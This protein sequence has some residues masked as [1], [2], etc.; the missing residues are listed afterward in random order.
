MTALDGADHEI[1]H[2][3]V[4]VSSAK[5][6]LILLGIFWAVLSSGLLVGIFA[7]WPR[8]ARPASVSVYPL[9]ATLIN[10]ES[11]Q[12]LSSATGSGDTTV[13]WSATDGDITPSGVFSAP[14]A[15]KTGPVTVTATRNSDHTQ[16]ASAQVTIRA[17][18]L[19]MN[20]S[21]VDASGMK[22]GEKILFQAMG[23]SGPATGLQWYLSGPGV[24]ATDG[25][26][27]V[28]EKSAAQAVVTAIDPAAG[29]KAAAVILLLPADVAR[30]GPLLLLVAVVGAFGALLAAV[31]S[32]V[33][34]VGSRTFVPSWS[35][36]YLFRPLFGAGLA[37][38]VFFAYRIGAVS[39]PTRGTPA[40]P[41]TAAFVAG[42]VGLFADTVLQKLKELVEQL[43][44]PQDTRSDKL[45][46]A[47]QTSVP[48]I[49]SLNVDGGVLTIQGNG[50]AAGAIVSLNG[51]N[52]PTTF[53]DPTKLTVTL[54]DGLTGQVSVIVTNHDGSRSA[55][56]S[57][58][59][60]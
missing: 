44:R 7:L 32:F 15:P 49:T 33:N 48:S 8:P 45:A 47:A 20:R 43:F 52:A 37:L 41:F 19:I 56:K 36:Y 54:P 59:A 24:I 16:T 6:W 60:T 38:I 57:F 28:H 1:G 21:V 34:F 30:D 53:V 50:F 31:R 51:H 11:L 3:T 25:T 9:V 46:G 22:D 13:I 18:Q 23:P 26:Y 27:T 17:T 39:G 40:D 58:T 29:R 55:A 35:F 14:A 42:M 5:A 4:T 12:F 10:G 2:S